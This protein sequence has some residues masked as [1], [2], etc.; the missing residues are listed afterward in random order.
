MTDPSGATGANKEP[1]DP[2]E[3]KKIELAVKKI[4]EHQITFNEFLGFEVQSLTADEVQIGFNMRPELVGHFLYGR[5][6]GGVISSVL[7]ATGGL[8]V[9]WGMV[10]EHSGETAAQSLDRFAHL[11]TIDL[12]IDYLRSG[13]GERFTAS[14]KTIRLGRRIA[15][16]Q[17]SLSNE[18]GRLIATGNGTYIV[19]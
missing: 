3:S 14:A 1:R 4:F 8:A 9:M 17:M 16:T 19:S 5:L 6:H 11:G 10:E 12:R 18:T 15:T 2:A 13:I 7:D